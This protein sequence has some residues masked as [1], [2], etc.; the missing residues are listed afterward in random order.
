LPLTAM[1]PCHR[2]TCPLRVAP[3][4]RTGL[5]VRMRGDGIIPA[6]M[7]S[8]IIALAG[9]ANDRKGEPLDDGYG[10]TP[11]P[12]LQDRSSAGGKGKGGVVGDEGLDGQLRK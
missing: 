12:A 6:D 9:D 11:H 2:P 7:T 1:T 8:A 4:P 5:G 3:R 10:L